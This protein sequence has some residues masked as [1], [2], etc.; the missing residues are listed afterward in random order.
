MKVI[1]YRALLTY[2]PSTDE[3][4]RH[5]IV[6]VRARNLSSGIAKAVVQ[7]RRLCLPGMVVTSVEFWRV[8]S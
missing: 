4:E 1:E 2:D 8:V 6:I 7:A 3:D 5:A